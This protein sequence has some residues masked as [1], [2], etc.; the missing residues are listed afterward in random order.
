MLRRILIVLF[1]GVYPG[2]IRAQVYLPLTDNLNV[3]SNTHLKILGGVYPL[4]DPGNDGLIRILN[5]HHVIIDGDSAFADGMQY[6]GCLI[7]IE[8]SDSVIIRNFPQVIRFFYA[9]QVFNSTNIRIENNN[10]SGNKLDSAGWINAWAGPSAA[11][12][13]GIMLQNS[14]NIRIQNNILKQQNDGISAYTCSQLEITGNDISWNTSYGIRMYFTDS[15]SIHHNLAR[16][17]RRP[18]TNPAAS[19]GLLLIVSN[20]NTLSYNDCSHSENGIYL[21]HF[22]YSGIPAN[23]TIQYNDCSAALHSAIEAKFSGG[24]KIRNN[25]CS[26]S[27][28]GMVLDYSFNTDIDSN[29]IMDNHQSGI[30]IDRGFHSRLTHN[31]LSGN[32]IGIEIWE[33]NPVSGYPN[34]NA[35]NFFISENTFYANNLAVLATDSDSL[36]IRGNTFEKNYSAVVLGGTAIADTLTENLFDRSLEYEIRNTTPF[37]IY[38]RI[39]T[40]YFADTALISVKIFDKQ[41]D[42]TKGQVLWKPFLGLHNPVVETMCPPDLTEPDAEWQ[43]YPEPCNWMGNPVPLTLSWDS[44]DV[45]QGDGSLHLETG[46]GW[47]VTAVYRPAGETI[48]DWFLVGANSLTFW[49]KTMNMNPGGFHNFNVKI[50]NTLGEYYL[51]STSGATINSSIGNWQQFSIPLS[52]NSTWLREQYGNIDWNSISHVEIGVDT[53]G[54]GFELWL[55]GMTFLL[56]VDAPAPDPG[57]IPV[58]V[59]P[60]PASGELWIKFLSGPETDYHF[61]L[62]NSEGKRVRAW[63]ISGGTLSKQLDISGLPPSVYLWRCKSSKTTRAGKL[64]IIP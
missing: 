57:E 53:Y 19:A 10:F 28:R 3:N 14:R 17:V 24:N 32:P 13:G 8:N 12:G 16:Y 35:Q 36:M 22:Q 37:D 47:L 50:V 64:V 26:Y 33:G 60:N 49:M 40:F 52:G 43:A 25:V 6:S 5:A 20:G 7:R 4:Q 30:T 31:F 55:D 42:A 56:G 45:I 54:V 61:Q 29:I 21:D 11:H 2:L 34:Q 62:L 38:A 39:N 1:F 18:N 41:D 63:N 23:N 44:M 9:I 46:T 48:S 51:Y 27:F 15:C 59:T 58:W